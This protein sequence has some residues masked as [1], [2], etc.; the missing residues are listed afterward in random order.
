MKKRAYIL[1]ALCSISLLAACGQ[2]AESRGRV[3]NGKEPE[4]TEEA[5]PTEEAGSENETSGA[6]KPEGTPEVTPAAD[7]EPTE[8]SDTD[9]VGYPLTEQEVLDRLDGVWFISESSNLIQPMDD[10]YDS[11]TFDAKSRTVTYHLAYADEEITYDVGFEHVFDDA[12]NACN[13]LSLTCTDMTSGFPDAS[14]GKS[15]MNADFYVMFT[16]QTLLMRDCGNG[17]SVLGEYGFNPARMAYDWWVFYR[18]WDYV[19][20]EIYDDAELKKDSTFFALRYED[21][22]SDCLLQEVEPEYFDSINLYGMDTSALAI[23]FADNAHP[24]SKVAYSYKGCE[25]LAHSGEFAPALLEV[26][27]DAKGEIVSYEEYPYYGLGYYQ[28]PMNGA[29]DVDRDDAR[30]DATD[31]IYLGEWVTKD[32]KIT[33]EIGEDNPMTG[34]YYIAISFTDDD[35]AF[36]NANIDG[37]NLSINQGFVNDE[38]RIYGTVE[39]TRNG[40]RYTVEDSEYDAVKDGTV[41]NFVAK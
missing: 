20:D 3:T 22:G 5:K 18:P 25:A 17:I 9:I 28:A 16:G 13:V 2:E 30:F 23:R 4:I 14:M 39:Q 10:L 38:Y 12:E 35:I 7:P 11:L 8:A 34:G 36:C 6:K 24:F 37:K 27:T 1:T 40:L 26:T 33:M 29:P 32:G 19:D 41:F 31:A 15:G 21:F